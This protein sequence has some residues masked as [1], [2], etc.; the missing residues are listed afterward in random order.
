M[1]GEG[2]VV[3]T[4]GGVT[5]EYAGPLEAV[6]ALLPLLATEELGAERWL[7]VLR[8]VKQARTEGFAGARGAVGSNAVVSVNGA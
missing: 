4:A 5:A 2:A 8:R 6:L 3:V 7:G 1:A